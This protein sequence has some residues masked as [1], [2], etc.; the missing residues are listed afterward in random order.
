MCMSRITT[1]NGYA[2][3]R[4]Q[5]RHRHTQTQTQVRTDTSEFSSVCVVHAL[6]SRAAALAPKSRPCLRSSPCP[7]RP[8]RCPDL[9]GRVHLHLNAR[10]LR[11]RGRRHSMHRCHDVALDVRPTD[12]TAV[13]RAIPRRKHVRSRVIEECEGTLHGALNGLK[14]A[15]LDP[16]EHVAQ[17]LRLE[18]EPSPVADLLIEVAKVLA[19]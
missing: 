2:H 1:N 14:S 16:E 19:G 8:C 10:R 9:T 3:V 17:E 13:L 12:T 5:T 4:I 6:L 15:T 11:R 18:Q 7:R